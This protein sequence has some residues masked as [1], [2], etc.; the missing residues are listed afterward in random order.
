V[1]PEERVPQPA[2]TPPKKIRGAK[3]S[4]WRVDDVPVE[5]AIC[6]DPLA[7]GSLNT[8]PCKHTFHAACVDGLRSFGLKQVCPMCRVELPPGGEKLFEEAG[9]RYL[10]LKRRVNR[11]GASWGALTKEQKREMNEVIGL[12]RKAADQGHAA[13][14]HNLGA[15]YHQGQGVKQDFGEAARLYR[16]AADQGHADGQYNLGLMYRMPMP[17]TTLALCANKVKV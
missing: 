17:S 7:S 4:D 2:S 15:A 3:S 5:C 10:V 14:Q 9:Q 16:M 8:L 1:T 11:G 12:L 13:A 6:L